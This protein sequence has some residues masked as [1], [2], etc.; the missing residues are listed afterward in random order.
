MAGKFEISRRSNGEFQFNLKAGNGQVI[1][2]SEGYSARSSC[3]NGIESVRRNSADDARFQR[4][5]SSNGKHYFTLTATNG[6]VIGSSEMYAD[7]SGRDNG[8]RSVQDNAPAAAI[9]DLT[10]A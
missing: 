8:I 10:A 1:L 2:T 6:Q 3:E 9:T 5:T 4:K 7:A